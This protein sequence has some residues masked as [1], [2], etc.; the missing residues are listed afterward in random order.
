[1][2]VH[3]VVVDP[4]VGTR[5]RTVAVRADDRFL[6][7]PD[8]GVLSW[9]LADARQRRAVEIREPVA[10]APAESATFHGR[11]VFAPAGA[12]LARGE[13]LETLG[14]P[15]DD[16][17]ELPRPAHRA[18]AGVVRGVVL[19]VDRFGNLITNIPAAALPPGAAVRVEGTNVGPLRR[20]YGDVDA[21]SLVALIGSLASLEVSVRDG[22]AADALGVTRGAAIEV[23]W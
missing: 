8:N 20:T 3:V 15:A 6:V 19:A 12:H 2:S 1:G 7:G 18:A 10:G 16:L 13:P 14:P 5:R 11:D 21:G 23:T 9:A 17:V 22:S 4:G